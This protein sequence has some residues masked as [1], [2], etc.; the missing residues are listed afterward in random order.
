MV[1]A[2]LPTGAIDGH[3]TDGPADPLCRGRQPHPPIEIKSEEG[4]QGLIV[5]EHPRT[6]EPIYR[7]GSGVVAGNGTQANPYVI[8]GW[9]IQIPEGGWTP[10]D[11]ASL[12]IRHTDAHLRIEDNVIAGRTPIPG[13]GIDLRRVSNVTIRGNDISET[14]IGIRA[15][16]VEN[17]QVQDNELTGNGF[18]GIWLR[19]TNAVQIV[20]NDITRG[21]EAIGAFSSEDL[22]I[23]GNRVE[24]NRVNG[25]FV[26]SSSANITDNTVLDSG[27]HG[28]LL[29]SSPGS[30][31]EH[32]VVSNSGRNGLYI[33]KSNR[34]V[35]W[36]NTV[37]D[38]RVGLE[39]A[40]SGRT[41]IANNTLEAGVELGGPSRSHHLHNMQNN[42]VNGA[43]LRYTRGDDDLD[44]S[45]LLGQVIAVN[46]TNLTVHDVELG[47]VPTPIQVSYSENVHVYDTTL[48][49]LRRR[50]IVVLES[51]EILIENNLASGGSKAGINVW[52]SQNA[53]IR[54]NTAR[55]NQVGITVA[56][57]SGAVV[58]GNEVTNNSGAGIH[59][60]G[61]IE[62]NQAP[63]IQ[64]ADNTV[65][66]N[67]AGICVFE[68]PEA[69]I[70]HNM[71]RQ[72]GFG[73]GS[74]GIVFDASSR[75]TAS[76]NTVLN[77]T[78]GIK[79][80]TASNVTLANNTV[81]HN[82]EGIRLHDPFFG[83]SADNR[84]TWN[85]ISQNN[86]GVNFTGDIENT[87]LRGNNIEANTGG[88]GLDAHHS[89]SQVDARHN[90]WGCPRGPE[91]AACQDVKGDVLVQP[92]LTEPSRTAGRG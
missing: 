24:D 82:E 79:L 47:D 22:V 75:G 54:N 51:S 4:P 91:H 78:H 21:R 2:A 9:C 10:V 90:W 32:N 69:R 15:R 92:W 73:P 28:L 33:H 83:P 58:V 87:T 25:I 56:T 17:V 7:P 20:D 81:T 29:R 72:N 35:V 89:E 8:A 40:R 49:D 13:E 12:L 67:Q 70:T 5:G 65:I 26:A 34:A 88:I 18:T 48:T 68:S 85:Q 80:V 64:I 16:Y 31:V 77:N 1:V 74:G 41:L 60:L 30:L 36:N 11:T 84:V 53:T 86:V 3:Q 66:N 19:H 14:G 27:K 76:N 6:G 59:C 55:D 71:V 57:S 50:G 43:P 38:N 63:G 44:L 61:G 23:D 39:L 37:R 62:T 52:L 45:G 42:T 46:T